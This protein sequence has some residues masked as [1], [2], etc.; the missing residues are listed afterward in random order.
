MLA[1]SVSATYNQN[2]PWCPEC[3]MEY[4]PGV[5]TC[6][7]CDISLVNQLPTEELNLSDYADM[8][9]VTY[10]ENAIEGAILKGV[11]AEQGI[12]SIIRDFI[13]SQ[14]QLPEAG[15]NTWGELLVLEPDYENAKFMITEYLNSLDTGIDGEKD[16]PKD[17]EENLENDSH[18]NLSS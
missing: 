7:D 9:P 13:I 17:S 18:N 11:L 10:L 5:L 16:F 12:H 2:M 14:H 6:P 4:V 15:M 8:V 1:V 3:R